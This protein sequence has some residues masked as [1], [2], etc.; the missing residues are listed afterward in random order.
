MKKQNGVN[1]SLLIAA[2]SRRK[3]VI[4]RLEAQLKVGLKTKG[5]T[6]TTV[7]LSDHD[8][9]RINQELVTLKSRV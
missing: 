3:S 6:A 1:H 7:P 9:K 5:P 8:I 2:K 4:E